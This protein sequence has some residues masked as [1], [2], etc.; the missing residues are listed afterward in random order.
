MKLA[1]AALFGAAITVSAGMMLSTGAGAQR[2]DRSAQKPVAGMKWNSVVTRKDGGHIFGNPNAAAKLKEY[3][4]YT[5]PHCANFA[6]QGDPALK[7][8]Y[9]PSGKVS[10][11]VR[12]VIR[13][14]ID[15]TAAVLAH[16]GEP[17]KFALNHAAIMSGQ[18]DWLKIAQEATPGQQ[19]RWGN[20]NRT[21]ARKAIASDLGFEKIME[22][23]GY[24]R[25]EIAKCLADEEAAVKLVMQSMEEAK[26]M[27][28]SGTP[29][30]ALNGKLLEGTHSWPVLQQNLDAFFDAQKGQ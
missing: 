7:L 24:S 8:I 12:H 26:E 11:E 18:K 19:Q 25:I 17:E 4:S 20:P 15:W 14:P 16:C 9:I 5:C 3:V 1:K 6:D 29:S 23:R 27:N 21:A 2:S 10:V 28:V 22:R 30:F 13:D